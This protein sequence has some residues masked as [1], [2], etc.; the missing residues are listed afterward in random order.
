MSSSA[1]L[2]ATPLHLTKNEGAIDLWWPYGP[3]VGRYTIKTTGEQTQGGLLQMLVRDARGGATPLHVHHDA[4]ET[5]YVI[6]G[7]LTIVVGDERF[8]ACAGDF[9]LGPRGVPHA[10]VIT[11]EEAEVLISYGPAGQQGPLGAGVAGFFREVA[12]PVQPGPMPAPRQPDA[13]DF[14]RRMLTYGIE[15]LG[16]PPVA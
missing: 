3:S 14:A 8:E 15:L 16:P 12:V 11:S 2:T 6:A 7:T 10:F 9:V 1:T 4:D 5:F 13:E